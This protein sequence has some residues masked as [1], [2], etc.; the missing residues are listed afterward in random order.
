[1]IFYMYKTGDSGIYLPT[2]LMSVRAMEHQESS[3]QS[4]FSSF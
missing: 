2:D 4:S 3:S 1:M